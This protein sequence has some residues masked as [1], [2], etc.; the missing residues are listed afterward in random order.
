V[1]QLNIRVR[2]PDSFVFHSAL[3][4]S[5]TQQDAST[6]IAITSEALIITEGADIKIAEKA[7]SCCT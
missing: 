4:S 7:E 1:P 2:N 5:P 6:L 3:S